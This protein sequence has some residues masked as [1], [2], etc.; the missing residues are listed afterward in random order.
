L[1]N[2]E[3]EHIFDHNVS[4]QIE[5]TAKEG[6]KKAIFFCFKSLHP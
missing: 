4:F 2:N 1:E 3:V 5:L 6:A